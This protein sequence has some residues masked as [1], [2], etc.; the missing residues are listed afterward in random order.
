MTTLEAQN[1]FAPGRTALSAPSSGVQMQ[2]HGASSKLPRLHWCAYRGDIQGTLQ[3]ITD[4]CSLHETVSLRNQHGRLVCGITALF[5]ASQRGH[6]EIVK[7]LVTNGASPV[8]PCFIQGSTELCTPAEVAS[9]NL[10]FK[11]SRYLKKAAQARRKEEEVLALDDEDRMSQVSNRLARGLE[12]ARSMRSVSNAG[13]PPSLAGGQSGALARLSRGSASASVRGGAAGA[14]MAASVGGGGGG[15]AMSV[16]GG[17]T[18]GSV[19][20][21]AA[22][23]VAGAGPGGAAPAGADV[24]AQR[25]A[26]NFMQNVDLSAFD[27]DADGPV[28]VAAGAADGK[29]G[30]AGSA[31]KKIFRRIMTW[32]TGSG[33]AA[34]DGAEAGAG[35][36]GGARPSASTRVR[37]A[38]GIGAGGPV[39]SLGLDAETVDPARPD[40]TKVLQRFL[41][42]L[43]LAH[44]QP[45][46]DGPLE[47]NTG[48]AAQAGSTRPASP[49]SRSRASP[50]RSV[51][52]NTSPARS[53]A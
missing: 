5:L 1:Q 45:E 37:G 18:A 30:G 35:T 24:E 44:W 31:V 34:A 26:L 7:L 50:P 40:H 20:L 53:R 29:G 27:P 16:D 28:V 8:Q 25:A 39:R 11:L 33:A 23:P 32:G 41:K 13:G 10:H 3:C 14:G 42:D 2:A 51:R 6:G 4:G 52:S 15:G 19:A 36:S 49:G 21:S 12:R 43:D 17:T 22:Y 9:L 48:G 38:S 47:L 46:H